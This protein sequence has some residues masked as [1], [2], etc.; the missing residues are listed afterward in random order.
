VIRGLASLA[1]LLAVTACGGSVAPPGGSSPAPAAG[2]SAASPLAAGTHTSAAFQPPVT[3][4]V[5]DGWELAADAA[6]YL[7]LRPA[8]SEVNGI[9]LFRDPVAASQDPACPATPEPGVGSTST[10]LVA[11][12]RERPGLTV[13]PPALA[14]VGGLRGVAIDVA[15]K[16]GW[17]A[18]CPFA[19]GS[20]TVPLLSSK[21]AGYHWVIV[22]NERLR[23]YVLDL[24]GGGTMIVDED[25]FDGTLYDDFIRAAAPIVRSMQFATS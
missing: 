8:G 10:E 18:S 16:D 7:Q 5:P 14:T 24:P 21:T 13:G 3:F 25:A 23:F 17:T 1:L 22:G 9:H 6:A 20:P 19:N 15:I 4:T 2:G 11:W 12:L